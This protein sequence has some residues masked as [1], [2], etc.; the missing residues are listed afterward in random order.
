MARRLV[1]APAPPPLARCRPAGMPLLG[2]L[3]LLLLFTAG[4]AEARKDRSA[5]APREP[6]VEDSTAAPQEPAASFQAPDDAYKN[7]FAEARLDSVRVLFADGRPPL[8]APLLRGPAGPLLS[9]GDVGRISG[10][11]FR[12]D[13]ETWRGSFTVDSTEVSFVLDTPIFWV[14]G[15]A[16]QTPAPVRYEQG[17]VQIPLAVVDGVIAPLMGERCRWDPFTGVLAVGGPRPWIETIDL[18]GG[19]GDASLTLAP[20]GGKPLLVRWDPNGELDIEVRGMH[21]PPGP[22]R[23]TGGASG[24]EV[25]F[26]RATT[27]GTVVRLRLDS[28]WLGV[29]IR[30]GRGE[31]S[32]ILDLTS[33]SREAGGGG[34]QPLGVYFRPPLPAEEQRSASRKIV[35]ELD[36][37]MRDWPGAECLH[38]LAES[39]RSSLTLQFGHQ[40]VL[41]EDRSE[42][43]GVRAPS[44]APEPAPAPDAD[45]WVGLRFER[46]PSES[47]REFLIVVPGPAARRIAVAA[48]GVTEAG[49]AGV[50]GGMPGTPSAGS[51]AGTR[52]VPWSQA[53]LPFAATSA[54]MARTMADH[55]G[56]VWAGRQV[57]IVQRPARIFRGLAMPAV[58]LYPV[59][60][61][62][63][64]GT[65][66]LCDPLQAGE[67]ARNLAFALDEFLHRTEEP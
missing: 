48:E 59:V 57:R 17:M 52:I 51:L 25:V 23:V 65:A 7:A 18:E 42:V 34:F 63:K 35:I 47:A 4:Q 61:G 8:G 15:A 6:A 12:W 43:S 9:L 49:L 37:R 22:P 20:V 31:G 5:P 1:P 45:C 32:R 56:Y 30:S 44:G 39:L 10:G 13:P 26:V 53:A 58:L 29:R 67:L 41:T 50:P 16:V 60:T 19:G 38:A 54:G 62:D 66:S 14:R 11:G 24:I 46:W 64:D 21:L 55:L 33:R 36:P 28:S 27:E 40:V 3:A 2:G